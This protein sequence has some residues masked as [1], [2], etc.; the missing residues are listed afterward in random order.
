MTDP[1]THNRLMNF[2]RM[3]PAVRRHLRSLYLTVLAVGIAIGIILYALL[4]RSEC[5]KP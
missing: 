3:Y 5:L 4:I 2:L 1:A